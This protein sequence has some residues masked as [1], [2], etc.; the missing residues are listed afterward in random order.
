MEKLTKLKRERD[1]S[2]LIV[3]RPHDPTHNNKQ[4]NQTEDKQRNWETY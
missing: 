4:K 2:T 3:G 1:N